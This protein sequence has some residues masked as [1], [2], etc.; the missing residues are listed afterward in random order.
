[1][2][3]R[4]TLPL[5]VLIL[6]LAAAL[7][8][9]LLGTQSL[10]ND[11]GNSYVQATRSFGDIAANAARDIHPPGYYWL[12]AL[13]RLL[14]G[15]SEFA[16]RALSAFAS[17]L[18]VAF[19]YALGRRLIGP[20]V[21]IVAALL[22][23]LITFSIY[24]AQE[25]RMYSL[26]AL[27]AAASMWALVGFVQSSRRV[28]AH[29]RAPLRHPHISWAPALALFNA[30]GL[31]TQYAYVLVMLAQGVMVALWLAA[32]LIGKWS[33]RDVER[34]FHTGRTLLYY[35]AA[36]LLT[37]ALYLPWLPTAYS[38]AT[39]WPNTGDPTIPVGAALGVIVGWL[40]FGVAYTSANFIAAAFLPIFLLAALIPAST[41]KRERL[42]WRTLLP[43]VWVLLSVGLFLA[44]GLF[45]EG[46]I[47]LLLPAQIGA[48]LWIGRSVD[49]IWGAA[50]Y[51][52]PPLRYIPRV[53]VGLV[54]L[55]VLGGLLSG[56]IPL[57]HAPDFQRDDYRSIAR[58]IT[59]D[60]DSGEAIILD[61]P[62]Q[63]EVFRY[64]YRGDVP[65]FALPPGLG[66]NDAE[67]LAA[68]REIMAGH[69]RIS[70]VFWGEAERDPN[71]VVEGALDTEAFEIGDTWY[72]DVRLARYV[73]PAEMTIEQQADAR[74]GEH[75]TLERYALNAD[76]VEP[77]DVLQTRLDW[78]TG[79]SLPTRY[80]VF[81]QLLDADGALVA[82]RDSEPGGGLALTTTWTPDTTIADNHALV[83]PPDL[84]P[85]EYTLI[86]GLYDM[87][88]PQ[89][90]LPVGA[91]DYLTLATIVVS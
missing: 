10:W 2:K 69:D 8:F 17:I 16:L 73:T 75:I 7:R 45:R 37:I 30:A 48:A 54:M 33:G 84:P 41:Y 70:A 80:K 22:V 90:R 88:N 56:L 28:G 55:T 19:T 38:Q 15:E 29:G 58:D 59:A 85:G 43:V 42:W 40:I 18:T 63:E 32:D 67:T 57:Y 24:Y 78:R 61:A 36:N 82:Q 5:L 62:N 53:L 66:G 31:W 35:V 11:E 25:A 44:L 27:W 20:M 34:T 1:M 46:N 51:F 89:A 72:G 64:Y 12:L 49:A 77:G 81:L 4:G 83:I 79:E 26:M 60:L 68:V 86:A 23:T 3:I 87:D 74:F 65:V 47:K 71:R 9:H 21:G 39:T 91:G 50:G 76:T 14:A 13:W 6:L 52:Q